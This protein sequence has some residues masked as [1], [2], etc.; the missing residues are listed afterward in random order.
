MVNLMM[1]THATS[2]A[3]YL[4]LLLEPVMANLA[5]F[6]VLNGCHQRSALSLCGCYS[7]YSVKCFQSSVDVARDVFQFLKENSIC[8]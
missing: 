2:G 3:H 7:P 1:V 8:K 5:C 4:L 6:M